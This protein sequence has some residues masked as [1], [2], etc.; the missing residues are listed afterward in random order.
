MARQTDKGPSSGRDEALYSGLLSR[1]RLEENLRALSTG[2]R[3]WLING[4]FNGLREINS[5]FGRTAVDVLLGAAQQAMRTVLEDFEME[6]GIRGIRHAFV[7][8]EV[9][10]VFPP[11][12]LTAEGV[13]RFL[14]NLRRAVAASTEERYF[15]GALI[16]LHHH[17]RKMPPGQLYEC[18]ERLKGDS[19]HLDLSRRKRGHLVI[20]SIR[21][22]DETV[23]GALRRVMGKINGLFQMP[24]EE[25][26]RGTLKWLYDR[27]KR[28][29]VGCNR[30][31][32]ITLEASYVSVASDETFSA[33]DL[34]SDDGLT[35]ERVK[36]IAD[37]MYLTGQQR[38]QREKRGDV[39]LS[40]DGGKKL[41]HLPVAIKEYED[42]SKR[43]PLVTEG[44]LGYIIYHLGRSGGGGVLLQIEPFYGLPAPAREVVPAERRNGTAVLRGNEQGMGL[45]GIN[46]L[47][48]YEMGD[49]V[50]CL[51]ED[52]V[53]A[54]LR[55]LARSQKILIDRIHVSRLIDCFRIYIHEVSLKPYLLIAM[56]K[57]IAQRFNDHAT[58]LCI[59]HL[60]GTIVFNRERIDG[61]TLLRRLEMTAL[62]KNKPFV[63]H[64]DSL[65]MVR[66]FGAGVEEEGEMVIEEAAFL[67]ALS[68][69]L[70]RG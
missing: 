53:F 43:L 35:E 57:N 67:S 8:D 26:L 68:L 25:K 40:I 64:D 4:D 12:T 52:L 5:L 29:F 19:I 30:G 62:A 31:F 24:S 55:E 54:G 15:V 65:L 33:L 51:L 9:T 70:L 34:S 27:S 49:R 11:S 32:A 48:G 36:L 22:F 18:I 47:C 16:N 6:S 50:V 10:I 56:L 37:R 44:S 66:H 59:S 45:K 2:E 38:L 21:R 60:R 61:G 58:G 1:H 42:P 69:G 20:A 63:L 13:N 3:A 7:G 17:L 46:E 23:L 41:F 39:L 28:R 14:H